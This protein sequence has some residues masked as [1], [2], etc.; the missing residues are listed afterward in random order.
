MNWF[1][2]YLDEI[3]KIAQGTFT[4]IKDPGQIAKVQKQMGQMG[5]P[6]AT[7]SPQAG[8]KYWQS[9]RAGG[10]KEIGMM[11]P[12]AVMPKPSGMPPSVAAGDVLAQMRKGT[13]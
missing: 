11:P 12:K 7:S 3:K 6:Q 8:L 1:P 13:M 2:A 5:T 9:L 10:S 4:S